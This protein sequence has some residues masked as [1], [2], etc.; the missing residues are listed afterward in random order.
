MDC[1]LLREQGINALCL[2]GLKKYRIIKALE[3]IEGEPFCYCLNNDLAGTEAER[4][5]FRNKGVKLA[6]D[7]QF[8]DLNEML[9]QAK[10]K[11]DSFIDMTKNMLCLKTEVQ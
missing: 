1:I 6:F 10:P 9:I 8:K 4:L 5:H 7:N 3:L 2:L 11:F